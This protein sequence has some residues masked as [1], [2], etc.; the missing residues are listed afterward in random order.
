LANT[1]S[2]KKAMAIYWLL[3]AYVLAALVWWFI[4][5]ENQNEKIYKNE[6]NLLYN[7]QTQTIPTASKN[8]LLQNKQ[9]RTTKHV[10]EG[11]V[12]LVVIAIGAVYIYRIVQKRLTLGQQQQ[13]FVMAV[14]HEL[15]TPIAIAKLNTETLQRR[16]LDDATQKKLLSNSLAELNRL[17]E[18]VSNIL[19]VSQLETNEYQQTKELVAMDD[20]TTQTIQELQQQL[21][22]ANIKV[23]KQ[24]TGN[25]LGDPLLIKLVISNLITNAYKY[26]PPQ[27]TINVT[28]SQV[29]QQVLLSVSD[30]GIGI[31]PEEKPKIFEKFYRVNNEN[32]RKTKGTGLG[33]YLCKKIVK[34]CGGSIILTD[35]KP[36]GSIFTV[37]LNLA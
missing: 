36:T 33:L 37:K 5:L 4:T 16:Q 32:V 22:H 9:R 21:P 20:I 13:N 12:F 10:A 27:S 30:Q 26:A 15:K 19:V 14:T 24:H 29:Q 8:K 3:L 6:Q 34:D 1:S 25:I 17:N 18:L 2:I 23:E 31:P 7:S 35:N 11:L 28:L